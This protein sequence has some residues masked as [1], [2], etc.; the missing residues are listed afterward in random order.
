MVQRV[1]RAEVW[2]DGKVVGRCGKGL[3]ALVAAHRD[4]GPNEA[5][6][7]ADRLWGLR[8]FNDE[9]GR[10]NV[11]L[12]DLPDSGEAKVLAVSNFTVYGDTARNR[13]PSFSESAPFERGRELFDRMVEELRRLGCRVETGVFGAHMEVQAACNGP[14]TVIVDVPPTAGARGASETG[15]GNRRQTDG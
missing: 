15:A 9:D 2:V 13:R 5:A 6:K 10:I 3:L 1:D 14:V 7:M 4:D 12:K 11:A 8:I